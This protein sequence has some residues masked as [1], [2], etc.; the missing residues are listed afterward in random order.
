METIR[1]KLNGED[2]YVMQ[3]RECTSISCWYDPHY[4]HW[5]LY[6][7]D[8]EGNQLCEATYAFGKADAKASKQA[9]EAGLIGIKF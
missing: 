1:I 3:E 8:A 5:V 2:S 6:P 9:M 7:V 4:R